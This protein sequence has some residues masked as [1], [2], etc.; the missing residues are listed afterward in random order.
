MNRR[1]VVS[2][3]VRDTNYKVVKEADASHK[4]TNKYII[5]KCY[6]CSMG[7]KENLGT[8]VSWRGSAYSNRGRLLSEAHMYPRLGKCR[9]FRKF[10]SSN[11]TN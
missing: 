2:S 8:E 3:L 7:G 11:K 10:R 5:A 6:K 9:V 4:Q 1:D